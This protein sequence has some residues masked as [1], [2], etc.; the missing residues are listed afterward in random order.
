MVAGGVI[1]SPESMDYGSEADAGV[2]PRGI[3]IVEG[4]DCW[5]ELIVLVMRAVGYQAVGVA[6]EGGAVQCYAEMRPDLIILDQMLGGSNGLCICSRLEK[7]VPPII[8][9]TDNIAL[10][11]NSSA[12]SAGVVEILE[13]PPRLP[14][15]M[16]SVRLLLPQPPSPA[17][18]A[19]RRS[20][21]PWRS[22]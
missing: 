3:L 18:A 19:A 21:I 8:L 17:S 2:K 22:R 14:Y 15:L 1:V 11:A 5:R 6:D 12:F 9:L 10:S 16:E 7:C 4:D 20:W 13:K